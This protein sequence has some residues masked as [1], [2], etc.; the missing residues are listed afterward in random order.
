[1]RNNIDVEKLSRKRGEGRKND[2]VKGFRLKWRTTKDALREGRAKM[3]ANGRNP[4]E[5]ST[6][7]SSET[8]MDEKTEC[9]NKNLVKKLI[10]VFISTD[11]KR[12]R[13]LK[14]QTQK[15]GRPQRAAVEWGREDYN[16]RQRVF[17]QRR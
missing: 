5:A 17:H 7:Q 1:V 10:N 2:Q 8:G 14:M 9:P 15:R 11:L 13:I 16:R 6:R 12:Y 3:V 4:T